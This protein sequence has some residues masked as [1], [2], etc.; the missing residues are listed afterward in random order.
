M[1]VFLLN[2]EKRTSP[3]VRAPLAQTRQ[4][5]NAKKMRQRRAKVAS[6]VVKFR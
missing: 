1:A 5:R 3:A 6:M 2:D 4:R